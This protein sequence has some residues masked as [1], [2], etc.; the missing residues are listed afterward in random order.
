[1]NYDRRKRKRP[2]RIHRVKDNSVSVNQENEA[3]VTRI[4]ELREILTFQKKFQKLFNSNRTVKE[5]EY[6]V[7]YKSK[8]TIKQQKGLRIAIHMQKA[9]ETEMDKLIKEGHIERLDE[10]GEDIFVSPVV[11]TRR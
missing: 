2:K 8:M 1:M 6:N 3:E 5:L 9:V 11:V 4:T 10:V 7:Q